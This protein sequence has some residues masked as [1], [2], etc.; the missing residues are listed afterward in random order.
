MSDD[1]STSQDFNRTWLIRTQT[2]KIILASLAEM[3]DNASSDFQPAP[4]TNKLP[5][6]YKRDI[7]KNGSANG[8][9]NRASSIEDDV[10]SIDSYEKSSFCTVLGKGRLSGVKFILAFFWTFLTLNP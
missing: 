2:G 6:E 1:L 3:Y 9:S 8:V 10:T 4:T 5:I 7:K